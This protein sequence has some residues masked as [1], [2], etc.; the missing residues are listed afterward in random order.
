MN[1]K[2][3]GAIEYLLI[4][5]AAILVVALVILAI[6]GAL[7]GGQNQTTTSQTQQQNAMTQLEI[8]LELA[9]GHIQIDSVKASGWEDGQTYF[10]SQN[11]TTNLGKVLTI[12]GADGI[13]ID[14]M[15]HTL[16]TT[17]PGLQVIYINTSNNITIQD[18]MLE[19]SGT[20]IFAVGSNNLIIKNSSIKNN[21]TVGLQFLVTPTVTIDNSEICSNATDLVCLTPTNITNID[22]KKDTTGGQCTI[23]GTFTSCP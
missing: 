21:S 1:P 9:K 10:V 17:V 6:T 4:I 5:A 20:G 16:Q 23:S 12:T 14:C 22:S 15:N 18:C 2:G 3:Q 11:I 7:T 13:T 8:E 19:N